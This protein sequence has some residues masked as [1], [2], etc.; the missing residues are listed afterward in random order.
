V[1]PQPLTDAELER[2][3]AVLKRFGD[4][5]AMNLEQLDGFANRHRHVID[6]ASIV[7]AMIFPDNNAV[8]WN[9]AQARL[10][11]AAF[12]VTRFVYALTHG[13]APSLMKRCS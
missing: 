9:V 2:L 5:R 11:V 1:K 4:K 12:V 8:N 3:S 10:V 13:V 6:S 7:G